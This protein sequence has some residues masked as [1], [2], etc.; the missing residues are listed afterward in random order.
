MTYTIE[1]SIKMENGKTLIKK[2]RM[3]DIVDDS[4]LEQT[5][6]SWDDYKAL[7][8]DGQLGKAIAVI[9]ED[10]LT[11]TSRWSTHHSCVFKLNNKFYRTHYSQ[12]ATE[13]QDESP[14]EYDGEWIEV[15]EVVQKE[16]TVIQY[17]S[18]ESV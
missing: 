14:F 12:G 13:S 17:V 15:D 9:I 8:N 7:E 2:E 18:K 11:D 3:Q 6:L 4:D 5:D 16:V 1:N 10:E